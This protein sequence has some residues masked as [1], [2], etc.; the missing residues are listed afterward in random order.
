MKIEFHCYFYIQLLKMKISLDNLHVQPKRI[1]KPLFLHQRALL[2]HIVKRESLPE[3]EISTNEHVIMKWGVIGDKVGS[4]KSI[5]VLSLVTEYPKKESVSTLDTYQMVSSMCSYY[6]IV[7]HNKESIYIDTDVNLLI[8][9]HSVKNQWINYIKTFS[10]DLKYTILDKL[11]NIE[12]LTLN[13][14]HETEL[15]IVTNTMF[16]KFETALFSMVDKKF[17]FNRIFI[18]EVDSIRISSQ[19]PY[20]R[21]VWFIT[22]SI[23]NL[24]KPNGNSSELNELRHKLWNINFLYNIRY[25]EIRSIRDD[26]LKIQDKI[27]NF[28]QIQGIVSKNI[29]YTLFSSCTYRLLDTLILQNTDENIEQSIQLPPITYHTIHCIP[30]FNYGR[31]L[32]GLVSRE[33]IQALDSEDY[34]YAMEI[35]GFD[36]KPQTDLIQEYRNKWIN[37]KS[38]LTNRYNYDIMNQFISDTDKKTLQERYNENIKKIDEKLQMI[39]H[40]I[41]QD[42]CLI[43]YCDASHKIIVNCCQN[44]FCMSCISRWLLLHNNC[45]LCRQSLTESMINIIGEKTDKH[46][47]LGKTKKQTFN[48]LWTTLINQ[49]CKILV[50]TNS[51]HDM[52]RISHN[53]VASTLKGTSNSIM[54]TIQSFQ[55][56]KIHTIMIDYT[57]MAQ[58]LNIEM[59]TDVILFN[60]MDIDTEMQCIGRAQRFGRITP[61]RVWK[62]TFEK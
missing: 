9:P 25:G 29:F 58:G 37:E 36:K 44:T 7:K 2:Y 47:S 56:G 4:G 45:P 24:Y 59:A 12:N 17:R 42:T 31:I 48:E 19:I 21:F 27:N 13:S 40:R 23:N 16:K 1:I 38:L 5:V 54:N 6:G 41:G 8:I 33:V 28:E 14:F 51:K 10:P 57:T 30:E 39:E 60:E 61:L 18:D 49:N 11:S 46:S 35:S 52:K 15:I 32:N 22:S 3:L 50:F 53:G 62:L 20:A 26:E 43:C 55:T 34:N